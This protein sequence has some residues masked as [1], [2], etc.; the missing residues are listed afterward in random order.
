MKFTGKGG[1]DGVWPV[2]KGESFDI[3]NPD[4]GIY[5]AWA[6]PG[7]ALDWLQ[8]K[9]LR[10]GKRRGD[11]PH[12]EFPAAY[13]SDRS[14]L[15]C[16][17]PRIAF[18]NIT[19]RTN[20]RTV[21]ACLVPSEVFITNAAPYFLW[22]RGDKRDQAFLL[23][24]L[25]SIPF[26]WYARRFVEISVNFFI[27]N[28]F[29][30]PR[31]RRDDAHWQRVVALAGRLACPDV[32]FAEWAEAVGVACGAISKDEKNDLINELD[33]VVA[34]LYGLDECQLTHV[35]ETFH[36]GWDYGDRLES[37]LRHYRVWE[38]R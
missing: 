1:S 4:T 24:I 11:S 15:P 16:L 21:I 26:D 34:H 19:N 14:T 32:R 27:I 31:P 37:V 8:S 30:V 23:G 13:L 7:P 38:R 9:R 17:T 36:E 33:A 5:Y 25:C 6:D 20:Q 28:P 2:Y 3:W 29:P 35:F 10:A 22:P 12:R 18:R